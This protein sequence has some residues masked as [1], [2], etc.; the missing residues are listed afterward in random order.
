MYKVD[1]LLS[2]FAI[3]EQ[4][5]APWQ[6]IP[7]MMSITIACLLLESSNVILDT[8]VVLQDKMK[9]FQIEYTFMGSLV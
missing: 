2:K 4:K 1:S 5:P 3:E 9:I 6:L 8:S 7:G